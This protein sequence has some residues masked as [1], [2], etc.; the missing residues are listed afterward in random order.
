M[1]YFNKKDGYRWLHDKKGSCKMELKQVK[2]AIVRKIPV[3]YL[4]SKY[5]VTACILSLVN[6]EWLYSLYLQSLTSNSAV[7]ANIEHVECGK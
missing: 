7:T 2:E 3:H 6:D 1:N 4:G 5:L